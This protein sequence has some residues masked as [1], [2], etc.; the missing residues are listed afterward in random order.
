MRTIENRKSRERQ[1]S[2]RKF[3]Q[4]VGKSAALEAVLDQVVKV[5]V[6]RLDGIGAGRDWHR[7]RTHRASDPQH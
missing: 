6:T 3:E 4:I 2:E 5:A 7:Q 1:T